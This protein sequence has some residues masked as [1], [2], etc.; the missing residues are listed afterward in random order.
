MSERTTH[1]EPIT[2]KDK[3]ICSHF[4]SEGEA[5]G[6]IDGKTERRSV[7]NLKV[8]DQRAAPRVGV[9]FHAMVSGSAQSE[10]TGIILDLS[11]SGCRLESP[12]LMLPGLS[13]E[14]SRHKKGRESFY[15]RVASISLEDPPCLAVPDCLL[16]ALPTTS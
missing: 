7:M 11:R 14:L 2:V 9:Q 3:A 5:I 4:L 12:L 10:G 1:S 8:D 13:L 6:L 16:E 15:D